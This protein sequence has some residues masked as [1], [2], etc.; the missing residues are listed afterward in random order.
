MS[1]RKRA[2][3]VARSKVSIAEEVIASIAGIAAAEVEGLGTLKGSV[4]DGLAAILGDDR[5]GKGVA[6]SQRGNEDALHVRLKI[7][8]RYGYPI[9]AVAQKV[10]ARVKQEIESMTG[11]KVQ[12]IDVYVQEIQ[13]SEAEEA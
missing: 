7:S 4:A 10:Q 13:F 11:L 2:A 6:A 1:E 12:L 8:V 9:H 3:S 5:K